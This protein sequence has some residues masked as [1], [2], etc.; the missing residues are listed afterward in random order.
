MIELKKLNKYYKSGQG[1]YHALRDINLQLPD[2]GLVFIVG[3]SGSG[4][5][6]LLNIIGGIDSYDNG[7]LIIDDV[8]TKN[9]NAKD[10]N[11]YR[12]TY[13]GF[14]FQ[15]FNVIKSLSVYDNIALS[16]ELHHKSPKEHHNEILD[17]IDKV[18]LKN[19]ENRAMNEISG[20]ERQRVAIARALIKNPKVIIADEP[21]GN[22]DTKNRDVV[23]DILKDLSKDRLVLIVTHDKEIA[24]KYGDRAITIK[25]GAILSDEVYNEA[26]IVY[27]D[28]IYKTEP[29]SPN[30]FTSFKLGF[31]GFL[32]HK[33]RF[34]LIILLFSFSLIFA[35][36]TVNLSLT[37][38]T[39]EYAYYQSD[40]NN[41]ILNIG[42]EYT[43]Y[44]FTSS[45]GFYNHEV[46][47]MLHKYSTDFNENGFE[48]YKSMLI[49]IPFSDNVN[50]TGTFRSQ[51]E[52]ITLFSSQQK[53]NTKMY[54]TDEE[55]QNRWRA[56][57]NNTSEI[58]NHAIYITDYIADNLLL[59]NY[60][61]S[62][63]QTY[64]DIITKS[65]SC[66]QM[67][68]P[69][70]IRNIIITEYKDLALSSDVKKQVAFKD[71][72]SY[73]NSIFVTS[74]QFNS[75]LNENNM[76][77]AYDN[78]VYNCLDKIGTYDDVKI[79][80]FDESLHSISI[81]VDQNGNPQTD[82]NGKEILLG[83]APKK[84]L[85]QKAV[86][87]A[88]SRGFLEKVLNTTLDQI[89]FTYN[90]D[91]QNYLMLNSY[92]QVVTFYV[93]GHERVP[94]PLSFYVTCIVESDEVAVYTTAIDVHDSYYKYLSTSYTTSNTN[95]GF[96]L[97]KINENPEVNA[98]IYKEMLSEDIIINNLSFKKLL[99]VS[100]FIDENIILFIGLFFVFCLFS[101]LIIFNFVI[102]NIK[103]ST[104]DIG[105]YLSLGMNGWKVSLIYLFQV[106][107]ISVISII[108]ALSGTAIFLNVL[109]A[110]FS[111]QALI[112]F[113]IIK[114]T[115]LG[116]VAIVSLSIL[117]PLLASD[118]N[119]NKPP[120]KKPIDIIKVS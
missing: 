113:K 19:K 63:V 20:G 9:F 109:D 29:V 17:I 100:N 42:N 96:P 90:S 112:D 44:G 66:D 33:L 39:L 116:V 31:K 65:I 54:L 45:S 24:S 98:S 89:S 55:E 93:G 26:N 106:L 62:S 79:L 41:N 14:I 71:N 49:E 114:F 111:A 119:N 18:G 69:L 13:I 60:F 94:T 102:I 35:G 25:D 88:V 72:V 5:S 92:G 48:F 53:A 7:E 68:N 51:I 86:Q 83:D 84:P 40:Y 67:N 4:K 75:I 81:S 58:N 85:P 52:R 99:I 32:Q 73:Y 12:N 82:E 59:F 120:L 16:L 117:T 118:K 43:N 47:E 80:P 28:K 27:S 36:S 103:N 101:I 30:I 87:M 105:I 6:T 110:N 77:Y 10:Y 15:E 70:Y 46:E 50:K 37:D 57:G 22:L 2:K 95:A 115:G 23:M 78:V 91:N 21:T 8:N 56:A 1:T 61:D 38:S 108:I 34:I 3:K 104:K 107:L 64:D 11:T 74:T 76:K 97:I